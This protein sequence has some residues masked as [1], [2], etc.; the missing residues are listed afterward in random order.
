[1]NRLF[2]ASLI[3]LS[4]HASV[5]AGEWLVPSQVTNV[6]AAINQAAHGDVITV[7]PGHYFERLDLSGKRLHLR[8][9]AGEAAT[10]LDGQFGG[11][12]IRGAPTDAIIEG[13]TIMRGSSSQGGG[14]HIASANPTI[15]RCTFIDNLGTFGGAAYIRYGDAAPRFIQCTFDN[16]SAS[17]GGAVYARD[18]A[19]PR[20]DNCSFLSSVS[21]NGTG[22]AVHLNTASPVFFDCEFVGNEATTRA[23]GAVLGTSSSPAFVRCTFLD[24]WADDEGGALSFTNGSPL[25][26]CSR[27]EFNSATFG[28]GVYGVASNIELVNCLLVGNYASG[29]GGAMFTTNAIP[30]VTNCTV[31]GNSAGASG[32]GV[33]AV[34][35]GPIIRN[36]IVWFNGPDQVSQFQAQSTVEYTCIQGGWSGLGGGNV[37]V[38][39][40]FAD[41]VSGD[42]HLLDVSPCINT[43]ATLL[44]PLDEMDLDG[45]GSTAD[46]LGLDLD[47]EA[48]VLGTQVDMGAYEFPL[49]N[50]CTADLDGDQVVGFR[51]FLVVLMQWGACDGCDGDI[52]NDGLVNVLDLLNVLSQW[53]P[54]P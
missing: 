50:V 10:V 31:A 7:G 53:G 41:R 20:F 23:G 1:M 38:D 37:A 13:F 24:N 17:Y 3:V 14:L 28:G 6:Q 29:Y 2:P 52:T 51:D 47:G 15:A 45:N 9:T 40:E 48:R 30:L 46:P 39:P 42:F 49:V 44:L 32:G 27:I 18:G 36:S 43:G 4:L 19:R 35:A 34:N 26:L 12:V 33:R 5:Y 25:V 21:P 22:G 54:C 16:N 11:T 8:S